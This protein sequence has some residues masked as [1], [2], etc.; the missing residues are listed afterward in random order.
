MKTRFIKITDLSDINLSAV[1]VYD[2]NNRYIDAQGNMY[3]LRFNKQVKRIEVI[4]II[5]TPAKTAPYF[6]QKLLQQKQVRAREGVFHPEAD[7]I[8]EMHEEGDGT[9]DEIVEMEFDPGQF[10]NNA[11]EL[12]KTHKDRL[13]GIITNIKNSK[14]V[15]ETNRMDYNVLNLHFRNIDV[16]GVRRIEK[17]LDSHKELASY[18]R[19]LSYYESKL[20]T[21]GRK[22]FDSLGEDG[23]RMKFIYYSEMYTSIKLLY[24]S[25]YKILKDLDFFLSEKNI[26]SRKNLTFSEKQNYQDGVISIGNTVKEINGVMKELKKLEE[27]VSES[28][29]F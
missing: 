2:L 9:L 4:K 13:G 3:G 29:N 6:Q 25:L 12:M 10:I 5:R 19:S 24:T 28:E 15:A 7:G 1:S 26:E 11:L 23:R 20:D 8:P 21:A 17:L 18:P 27:F 22:I 16:E 14:I